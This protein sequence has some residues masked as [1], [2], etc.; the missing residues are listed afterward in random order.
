MA[1]YIYPSHGSILLTSRLC[2]TESFYFVARDTAAWFPLSQA[3]QRAV[4]FIYERTQFIS[5]VWQ[6]APVINPKELNS[7]GNF[8]FL[9][10]VFCNALGRIMWDS[11]SRLKSRID[12]NI[13][14]VEERVWEQ[15]LLAQQGMVTGAKPDDLQINIELEQKNQWYKRPIGII[16]LGVAIGILVQWANLKF[17]LLK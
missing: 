7:S 2:C 12:D 11:A 4:Y 3:I 14:R 5:W 8:G 15:E 13:K 9:F 10:I 17:G 1:P 16:L 6:W